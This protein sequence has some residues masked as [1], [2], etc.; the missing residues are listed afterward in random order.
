[1]PW[2]TLQRYPSLILTSSLSQVDDEP[3]PGRRLLLPDDHDRYRGSGDLHVTR[4]QFL[5]ALH[6]LLKPK[7]YLEVGVQHGWSLDLASE[8]DLAI[9]ID[10]N[11]LVATKGNQVICSVTSNEF[12][13]RFPFMIPTTGIDMAFIDGMHLFEYALR[14]FINIDRY[15]H[16]KSM[17]V[18]DDVL[19]RNQHEAAREQCPGDWTGDVWKVF[20]VL[21]RYRT[22]LDLTLVNTQ[23]TGIL[24]VTGLHRA[25]NSGMSAMEYQEA[26]TSWVAPYM[27]QVPDEVL[28]R[29]L[30]MDPQVVLEGLKT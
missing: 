6:D 11:P 13:E 17:V 16:S 30:A 21:R 19:P 2:G 12:F 23:P 18:F 24:M 10:P 26:V 7:T 5:A 22:D 15:T 27:D 25:P 14:D 3:V 28:N 1:M 4:H 29:T 8:A 20:Y 9:G